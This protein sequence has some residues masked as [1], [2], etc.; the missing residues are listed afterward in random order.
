MTAEIKC[1][2]ANKHIHPLN[3]LVCN[4]GLSSKAYHAAYGSYIF[5]GCKTRSKKDTKSP[6]VFNI[7]PKLLGLLQS[8]AAYFISSSFFQVHILNLTMD[9]I[10][11]M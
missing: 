10:A 6:F 3:L 9:Q 2:L 7:S 11:E 8:F 1:L 5:A 4:A